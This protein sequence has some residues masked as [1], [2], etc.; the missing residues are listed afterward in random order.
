M[1]M[2][3]AILAGGRSTRFGSDKAMAMLPDGRTL[4]DHAIA[5]LRPHVAQIVV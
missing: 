2:L 3:G 1:R 5:T 4:M